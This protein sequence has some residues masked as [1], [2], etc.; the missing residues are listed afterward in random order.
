MVTYA[1]LEREEKVYCEVIIKTETSY[2]IP[3]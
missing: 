2:I 1:V 3:Y